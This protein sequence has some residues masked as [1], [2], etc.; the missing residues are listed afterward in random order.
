MFINSPSAICLESWNDRSR[1]R[2]KVILRDFTLIRGRMAW[3]EANPKRP[4]TLVLKLSPRWSLSIGIPRGRLLFPERSKLPTGESDPRPSRIKTNYSRSCP[5]KT[6]Q[7]LPQQEQSTSTAQDHLV[8]SLSALPTELDGRIISFLDTT[9]LNALSKV[10]KY[11]HKQAKEYL[12]RDLKFTTH[13]SVAIK[14][15]ARTILSRRELAD[16]IH[17]VSLTYKKE[18]DQRQPDLQ[19]QFEIKPVDI[20]KAIATIECPVPELMSICSL[21]LE[22]SGMEVDGCL[23]AILLLATNLTTIKWTSEVKKT[24]FALLTFRF[25]HMSQMWLSMSEDGPWTL[26]FSKLQHLEIDGVIEHKVVDRVPVHATLRKL[27]IRNSTLSNL[28][29]PY[30]EPRTTILPL[31]TLEIQDCFLDPAKLE[32]AILSGVM[33]N[34]SHLSIE[35][36]P[37]HKIHKHYNNQRLVTAMGTYLPNLETLRWLSNQSG[38]DGSAIRTLHPLQKLR[39]LDFDHVLPMAPCPT[40]AQALDFLANAPAFFPPSL[41]S[42]HFHEVWTW[43]FNDKVDP[44]LRG[45]T[46]AGADA[47]FAY[48]MPILSALGLRE[49]SMTMCMQGPPGEDDI[50]SDFSDEGKALLRRIADAL[51]AVGTRFEVFRGPV[52]LEGVEQARKLWI[53]PGFTTE[54]LWLRERDIEEDLWDDIQ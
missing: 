18:D 32:T 53:G 50:R 25:L 48:V 36:N 16:Y 45:D 4:A 22:H 43:E 35:W 15:L 31:R 17:S 9:A 44:L 21:N 38:L 8:M 51:G 3:S 39:V 34:I 20:W 54:E 30:E 42:L 7:T 49:L 10:S 13:H 5:S 14:R 19:D 28:L 23:A 52:V 6:S 24:G 37:Y 27:A 46:G 11:Y 29:L 2:A 33:R 26:P 12:Y 1:S 41:Q 47:A 40:P